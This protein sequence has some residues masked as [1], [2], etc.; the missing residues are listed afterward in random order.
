MNH[1]QVVNVNL[2]S[3]MIVFFNIFASLDSFCR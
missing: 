2:K 1:I 3:I